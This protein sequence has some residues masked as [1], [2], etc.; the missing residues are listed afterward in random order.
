MEM[1]IVNFLKLESVPTFFRV[2]EKNISYS[3]S[4]RVHRNARQTKV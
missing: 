3:K 2:N 4:A 1:F